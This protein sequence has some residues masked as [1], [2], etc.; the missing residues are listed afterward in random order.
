[1]YFALNPCPVALIQRKRPFDVYH[2][3]N[4]VMETS[5]LENPGVTS[6]AKHYGN[7]GKPSR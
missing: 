5:D 1:M 4:S 6:Q 7:H 2:R 3:T